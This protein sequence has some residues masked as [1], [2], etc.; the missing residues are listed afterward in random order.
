VNE[1]Y[2]RASAKLQYILGS[3]YGVPKDVLSF[4]F[5]STRVVEGL[6][7]VKHACAMMLVA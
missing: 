6:Q 3:S 5:V 1:R 4:Y 7:E 2:C